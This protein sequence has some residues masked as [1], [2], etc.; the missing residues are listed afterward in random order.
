MFLRRPLQPNDIVAGRG[1]LTA[2]AHRGPDSQGEWMDVEHG[3]YMGHRRL[4][5]IDLSSASNQPILR[6][7][8]AFIFNG[9]LYNFK[10]LR[11][12]LQCFGYQFTSNGDAEVFLHGWQHWG[13]GIL[14]YAEGM[15]ALAYW[16]GSK[17]TL[18]VD[19]FGEKPLFVAETY[20]GIYICSEIEPLA[21]LLDLSPN[22][23]KEHWVAYLSLGFVPQPATFYPGIEMM[24]PASYREVVGGRCG[25]IQRYWEV[26]PPK[27]GRGRP[28]QLPETELDRLAAALV[29]SLRDR[30][31]ADVPLTLFLSAGIDSALVAALCR[32][33]VGQELFCLTVAFHGDAVR[34]ESAAA[35]KIADY[36]GFPHQT[37][38]SEGN[39][40]AYR[41]IE[42]LG[43]PSGAV[44][45]LPMEQIS[46]CA[47]N[48]G[49]KV[50]LTGL[51][52]DEITA[53]YGKHAYVWKMRRL[54]R[55]PNVIRHGGAYAFRLV[56]S[57]LE[58]I[59]GLMA[60]NVHEIYL[61]VKNY[62]ALFW[63]R[64]LPGYGDWVRREFGDTGLP[65]ELFIP[66]Y[67][68]QKVMP[69]VHL[70]TTDHASMR[71]S[72]ELR[73]PF[74]SRKVMEVITDWDAR[75]LIAFGQKSILRRILARYLPNELTDYPKTGFSFPRQQL[76]SGPAPTDLPGMDNGLIEECW[77]HRYEGDGWSN[78]AVRLRTAE[79]FFHRF[80]G[81]HRFQ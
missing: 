53:G 61:A 20:E 34:D 29:E 70:Y 68:L 44:G 16:D 76:V 23:S 74:L 71:H 5:I 80:R 78:I 9:E 11:A 25:P 19:A 24:P 66:R 31:V 28:S 47:R 7:G 33:E 55:S 8:Q 30:L 2:L 51:G 52:G 69:A 48:T 42:L 18:A 49:Y 73:T 32:H 67:E 75:A 39:V 15:F 27:V 64:L 58:G 21:Q 41:L 22:L 35:A 14:D 81:K 26:P 59:A 72:L 60:A 38:E 12:D 54:F 36:L 62:P 46:S 43:Q 6:N 79:W 56:S 4:S 40:S 63:L 37:L 57:R 50:A 13:R 1:V 77:R 45:I 17:G 65:P 10:K 3:V